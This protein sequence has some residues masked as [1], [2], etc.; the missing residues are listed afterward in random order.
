MRKEVGVRHTKG[1][2]FYST[3]VVALSFGVFFWTNHA[4][5]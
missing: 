5:F 4:E 2:S 3:V 1:E